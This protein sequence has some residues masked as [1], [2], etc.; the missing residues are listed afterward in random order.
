MAATWKEAGL[1]EELLQEETKLGFEM[2]LVYVSE[3]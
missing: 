2:M 1:E 3:C